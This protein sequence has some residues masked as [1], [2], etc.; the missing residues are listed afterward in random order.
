M[1]GIWFEEYERIWNECAAAN[2]P[3]PDAEQVTDAVTERLAN[4][5]D[6]YRDAQKYEGL[7]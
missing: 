6:R 5:A 4:A 2:Q 3:E 1:R 7:E